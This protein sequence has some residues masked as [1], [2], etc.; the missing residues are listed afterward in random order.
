[1]SNNVREKDAVRSSLNR[2]SDYS[3]TRRQNPGVVC[4]E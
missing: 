2:P 3:D 1:M 4:R